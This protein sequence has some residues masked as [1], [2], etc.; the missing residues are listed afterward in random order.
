[1]IDSG[2]LVVQPD[3]VAIAGDW[4]GSISWLQSVIPRI[5]REAPEVDTIFHTGDFGLFPEA[6]GKGFLAAVDF[7]CQTANIRRV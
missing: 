5:H 7:W 2:P 4:H 3:R 6:H 1:M